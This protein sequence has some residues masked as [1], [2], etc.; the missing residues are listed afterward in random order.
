MT[1]PASVI[2]ERG[3][4]VLAA[5][6]PLRAATIENRAAWLTAS[7]D[8]LLSDALERRAALATSTGLSIP[9]VAWG[10]RTTLETIAEEP[11]LSL[12]ERATQTGAAPVAMLAAVLAGNV[13]TASVRGIVV[14]LLLGVPV[15]VKASSKERLFPSMLLNALRDADPRLGA[16]ADLVVFEGGDLGREAALFEAAEVIAVYGSDETISAIRS[17]SKDKTLLE[18]G[19]G[20]S[21]AYC[22][23]EALTERRIEATIADLSIDICAYDQR[24]CLSP[25]V[26]YVEATAACP[27]RA[28]AKRLASRGLG[29]IGRTLP[30]GPL[31]LPVGA[32]QTQWRGVA[33]I[34]GTLIRGDTYAICVRDEG[35]IR[36]SPAYRNVTVMEVEGLA[37][38]FESIEPFATSLKCIGTDSASRSEVEGELAQ[39]DGLD[40]YPCDLGQ[41]QTPP[42]DAPADGKPIWFGLLRPQTP[43]NSR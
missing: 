40:A 33:Q 12:A 28:F 37:G 17:R 13:F 24:G 23:R 11:L 19:H 10:A 35:P 41:M 8:L 31:P 43:M 6:A 34:E 5:G 42:L 2:G 14:P 21:V 32:A 30:R 9:M 25:Q 1:D 20:V 26:I 22:G 4:A 27:V 15:L 36:W 7:A 18:H 39:R 29:P 38:A 16:A 3:A